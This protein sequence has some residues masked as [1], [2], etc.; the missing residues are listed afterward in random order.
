MY[1]VWCRLQTTLPR[2][3][4]LILLPTLIRFLKATWR[5]KKKKNKKTYKSCKKYFWKRLARASLLERQV[6]LFQI[7]RRRGISFPEISGFLFAVSQDLGVMSGVD[8]RDRC[9]C[10]VELSTWG[11]GGFG[12]WVGGGCMVGWWVWGVVATNSYHL[13]PNLGYAPQTHWD[14]SQ[15]MTNKYHQYKIQYIQTIFDRLCCNLE[16]YKALYKTSVQL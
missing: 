3:I 14:M 13:R 5:C 15:N 1:N 2:N 6:F 16:I 11:D 12:R 9:W 8:F 7:F 4:N 10:S